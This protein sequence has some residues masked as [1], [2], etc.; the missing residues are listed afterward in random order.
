MAQR[1]RSAD[2]TADLRATHHSAG[3]RTNHAATARCKIRGRQA[4]RLRQGGKRNKL[5][6]LD[7]DLAS[8]DWVLTTAR[9]F[10]AYRIDDL[11]LPVVVCH[12]ARVPLLTLLRSTQACASCQRAG[13]AGLAGGG[14]LG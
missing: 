2:G 10:F 5:N 13:P 6:G 4:R 7:L 3:A 12:G 8:V 11:P 1:R 9:C 14:A